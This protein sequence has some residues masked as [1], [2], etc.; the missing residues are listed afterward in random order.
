VS[1]LKELMML[2]LCDELSDAEL[3]KLLE[4]IVYK[5]E[6][7]TSIL[8]VAKQLL[9]AT[10]ETV[11]IARTLNGSNETDEEVLNIAEEVSDKLI[12]RLTVYVTSL[13]SQ[14]PTQGAAHNGLLN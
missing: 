13:E 2:T 1:S 12:D 14:S 4:T 10:T 9:Q 7:G 6:K 8:D 11:T 3:H 5:L